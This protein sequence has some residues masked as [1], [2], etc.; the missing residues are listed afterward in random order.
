MLNLDSYEVSEWDGEG[1]LLQGVER[2]R[3][4]L[5]LLDLLLA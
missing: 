4:D 1:D 2:L 5:I 3:P